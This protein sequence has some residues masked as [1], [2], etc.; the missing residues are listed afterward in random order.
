[1]TACEKPYYV[2]ALRD[3]WITFEV[4]PDLYC[5]ATFC[6]VEDARRY[7]EHAAER[8]GSPVFPLPHRRVR[9]DG[10]GD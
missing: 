5:A 6:C 3:E 10:E 9:D 4:G 7:I 8:K 2:I 1:M